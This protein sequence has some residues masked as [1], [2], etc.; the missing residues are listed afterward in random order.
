MSLVTLHDSFPQRVNIGTTQL[1]NSLV[2]WNLQL[3]I[4]TNVLPPENKRAETVH[5]S[6]NLS[7]IAICVGP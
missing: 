1:L 2:V 4:K 6:A 5:Y 3:Q 7:L